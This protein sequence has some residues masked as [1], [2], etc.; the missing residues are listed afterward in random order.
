MRLLIITAL[1]ATLA[2]CTWFAPQQARQAAL[3]VGRPQMD[4][5][6]LHDTVRKKNTRHHSK[7]NTHTKKAKLNTVLKMGASSSA[8]ADDKSNAS[9]NANPAIAATTGTPQ[10]PQPDDKFDPVMKKA[11]PAI[12]AK[13]ANAAS[14]KLLEMKRA[15]KDVLGKSVDTI[16]GYVRGKSASGEETVDRPFLYLVQKD[17][18]Y[19]GG[20][21]IATSP[22]HNLCQ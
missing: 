18:A 4:L 5:K 9:I 3:T 16:C 8:Q 22:Y 20:Y 11:I 15:E 6:L 13:M 10:S 14:I 21:N 17:E 19:I 1:G 2:G 12:A 7:A